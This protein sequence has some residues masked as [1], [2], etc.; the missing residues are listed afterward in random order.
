MNIRWYIV[1]RVYVMAARMIGNRYI[2]NYRLMSVIIDITPELLAHML[3]IQHMILSTYVLI[4][5]LDK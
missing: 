1:I 3:N 5:L 2:N 4:W